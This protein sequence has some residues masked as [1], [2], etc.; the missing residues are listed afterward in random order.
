[1]KF[2]KLFCLILCLIFTL[3]TGCSRGNGGEDTGGGGHQFTACLLGDPESLDPQIANDTSAHTVISNIFSG[4]LKI[5]GSGNVVCDTAESYTVSADGLTYSFTLREDNYWV[6]DRNG[7]GVIEGE[8]EVKAIDGEMPITVPAEYF[9]VT[10]RDYVFAFNRLLSPETKSPFREDYS[11]IVNVRQTG[12]YGLEFILKH[13]N[14]DFPA[15]LTRSAAKPCNEEFFNA[16]KGRYGRTLETVMA[17]GAFYMTLWF[18]DPY[19]NRN[20]L[21][22]RKNTVNSKADTVYPSYVCFN[23]VRSA[24]DAVTLFREQKIET[25]QSK[26]Y[27]ANF[28]KSKYYYTPYKSET[29]GLIYNKESE[30]YSNNNMRKAIAHSIDRNALLQE[31]GDDF[32]VAYGIIPSGISL[33]GRS[34]RELSSDL[35]FDCYDRDKASQYFEIAKYELEKK[36]LND[37]I[38]VNTEYVNAEILPVITEQLHDALG[39]YLTFEGVSATEFNSRITSGNYGLALYPVTAE[40]NSGVSFLKNFSKND[41]TNTPYSVKAALDGIDRVSTAA[42]YVEIFNSIEK[43]I[44]EENCFIPLFY[45]NV[46]TVSMNQCRDIA[47]NPFTGAVDFRKARFVK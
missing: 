12:D 21:Y 39:F 42:D 38:L 16:S 25:M 47:Y 15:L 31:Q 34:Y 45:K 41:C 18:Y 26:Y 46:Y 30:T 36:P 2:K 32:T 35:S 5:D 23:I 8:K 1:M 11:C 7:N 22:L 24:E 33:L 27:N 10:S 3:L 17:N 37:S 44:L 40:Y 4:L 29:L 19:G 13:P 20:D 43:K 14:A 9:N 6:F 28:P